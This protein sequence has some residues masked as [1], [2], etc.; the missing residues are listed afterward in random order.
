MKNRERGVAL[1]V[2]ILGVAII[3]ALAAGMFFTSVLDQ[4]L[5]DNERRLRQSFGLAELG[6]GWQLANWDPVTHNTIP[7]FPDG[8]FSV[9]RRSAASGSYGGRVLKLNDNLYLIEILAEDSTSG[10][11]RLGLL[12]RIMP[13]PVDIQ[14]A[15]AAGG[16]GSDLLP[17]GWTDCDP[18]PSDPQPPPPTPTDSLP[19]PAAASVAL[20]YEQLAAQATVTLPGGA[21]R[22]EP[23]YQN[24]ACN[25]SDPTNW[26]D[27]L[28]RTAPCANHFPIIHIRGD[29]ALRG[30]QGQGIL[31]VD[32]D[33]R[34]EG[35]YEFF[36]VVVVRGRLEM[37]DDAS[38][39]AHFWGGVV[40]TATPPGL[41]VNQS[42]CL[43][44][45]VLRMTGRP[46]PL[47]SRGW[48]QLF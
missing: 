11:T 13:L 9:P 39:D 6:I 16:R 27:G 43:I 47:V 45:Q 32:G 40:A 2:A 18:A 41:V 14:A 10:A 15:L 37:A 4:R 24:G 35:N 7:R 34:L 46:V 38:S 28:T 30:L 42:K 22:T 3:A 20:G 5:A 25:R 19:A 23:T 17:P 21:Y 29:A 8:A 44:S 26:G 12:A 33:L 31:L 48:G 1:A 36:G